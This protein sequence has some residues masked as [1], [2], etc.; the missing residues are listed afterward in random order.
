MRARPWPNEAE[1]AL[2][3]VFVLRTR[4]DAALLRQRLAA[5]PAG[6]W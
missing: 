4:E 2:D 3:G 1:A 6:C 5:A